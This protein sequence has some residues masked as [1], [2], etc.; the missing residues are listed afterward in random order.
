MGFLGKRKNKKFSYTPRYLKPEQAK[1]PYEISQKFDDY[2][3][4][5]ETPSTLKGK[6]TSAWGEY[7]ENPSNP[8]NR[9]VLYIGGVLVVFFLMFMEFDLSMFF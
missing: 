7:R 1:S 4:T 3:T 5:L 8:A 2:R 9:R 6:F